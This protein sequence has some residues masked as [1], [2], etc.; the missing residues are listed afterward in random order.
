[1]GSWIGSPKA[2]QGGSCRDLW[3]PGGESDSSGQLRASGARWPSDKWWEHPA[4]RLLEERPI[5]KGLCEQPARTALFFHLSLAPWR[6]PCWQEMLLT[7]RNGQCVPQWGRGQGHLSAGEVITIAPCLLPSLA[8]LPL[9]TC[10]LKS[11]LSFTAKENKT[12]PLTTPSLSSTTFSP[13]TVELK[14]PPIKLSSL[15]SGLWRLAKKPKLE[16]P[17]SWWPSMARASGHCRPS[18][19]LCRSWH[20]LPFLSSFPPAP[21]PGSTSPWVWGFNHH[22]KCRGP[23][24]SWAGARATVYTSLCRYSQWKSPSPPNFT[25]STFSIF[26]KTLECEAD[27][28]WSSHTWL[29]SS[30]S[31]IWLVFSLI[32][33]AC[34]IPSLICFLVYLC[35]ISGLVEA[36]LSSYLDDCNN[37]VASFQLWYA[38][39]LKQ[40]HCTKVFIC[41]PQ[42]WTPLVAPP[43]SLR[44]TLSRCLGPLGIVSCL[45]QTPSQ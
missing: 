16:S 38:L 21:V 8:A 28:C 9:L 13:F 10:I 29:P 40:Y 45:W 33:S 37:F 30:I 19:A 25:P 43:S 15:Q 42:A 35:T 1:M 7:Q 41:L 24:W 44:L 6:L 23:P 20:Q 32:C 11:L 2:L 5:A 17:Q 36:L 31:H 4:R 18:L 3:S 26:L 12:R 34:L 27:T 14:E 39:L 22:L